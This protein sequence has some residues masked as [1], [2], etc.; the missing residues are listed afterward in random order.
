MN[1]TTHTLLFA[2]MIPALATLA[3]C[4]QEAGTDEYATP[5][6][7]EPA[8]VA[9]PMPEP[10]MP[11][12]DENMGMEGDDMG[13]ADDGMTGDGMEFADMDANQ[14][15][16]ISK[17]ELTADQMLYEHFDTADADG[18]GMLTEEEVTQ[19]RADMGM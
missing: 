19:H 2:L 17:D 16:S 13:M 3:A 7:Q 5:A 14:D 8:P 6:A 11:P 18:D 4:N 10:A 12:A 1:K 15:G 9:E